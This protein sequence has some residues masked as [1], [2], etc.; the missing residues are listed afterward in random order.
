MFKKLGFKKWVKN[1]FY[2][3][4]LYYYKTINYCIICIKLAYIKRKIE[5]GGVNE[6]KTK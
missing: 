4:P 6:Q 1:N 3:R 2:W 5:Q